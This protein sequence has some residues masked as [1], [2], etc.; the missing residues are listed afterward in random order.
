[1]RINY[2]RRWRIV[3]QYATGWILAFVFLSIVRGSGTI[4]QGSA[5]FGLLTAIGLSA[6]FGLVVG[7]VSGCAQIAIEERLYRRVSLRRLLTVRFIVAAL[8]LLAINVAGY[9]TVTAMRD[10]SIGFVEFTFEP[11]SAAIFF[12]IL[13]VDAFLVTLRHVN[14]LLGEGNLGR[15]IRGDFYTPREEERIVMFLDLRSS[16]AL[17]ETLGHV[18]YSM[19]IQDCFDD[20]GVVAENDAQVYQYLGDGVILTWSVE[21]GLRDRNC[22]SAWSRFVERLASRASYYRE[23][24]D[25]QPLFTAGANVGVVTMTEVGRFRREIAYHGDTLNT[26]ARIQGLCGDLD[27]TLLIPDALRE[28]LPAGDEVF[29]P[30]GRIALRGRDEAV[31]ILAV[32]VD[33]N[34]VELPQPTDRR[35]QGAGA[36]VDER[37]GAW[38]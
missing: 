15:L 11:G 4:E 13:C 34:G 37:R 3:R 27:E 20:L 26:A 17:A 10:V 31:E 21:D 24:Y 22:I 28:R 33:R 19:F 30:H 6:L 2:R 23:R 35:D 8:F 5:Q 36:E 16:T 1:M 7:A 12:Y 38:N 29:V 32:R 25:H 9:V 14:L 18:R